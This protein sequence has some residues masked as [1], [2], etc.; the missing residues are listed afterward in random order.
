MHTT[1]QC[2]CGNSLDGEA[3]QC[4]SC[5][6][7]FMAGEPTQSTTA[8]QA[9]AP[10]PKPAER[11]KF[12][13]DDVPNIAK[14]RAV[15]LILLIAGCIVGCGVIAFGIWYLLFGAMISS[16]HD[17]SAA[18][19]RGPLTHGC[20]AYCLKNDGR[21]PDNL[22]VLLEKNPNG[23]PYLESPDAL[24]DPW[25]RPYQY[26]TNGPRN[27]GMRPDIWTVAPDGRTIGNWPRE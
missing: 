18:Q 10:L 27:K 24:I 5:G 14:S 11:R 16:M 7:T 19:V 6:A 1:L 21:F 15:P 17:I 9:E 13:D 25:G 23:G 12:P 26:D 3:K 8:V 2:A 4:P 20:Q 22:A